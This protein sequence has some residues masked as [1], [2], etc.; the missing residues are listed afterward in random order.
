MHKSKYK[1][2]NAGLLEQQTFRIKAEC[3]CPKETAF[4]I[5]QNFQAV[6]LIS[7]YNI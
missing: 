7:E 4:R 3:D 5:V 1:S 2:V 6:D